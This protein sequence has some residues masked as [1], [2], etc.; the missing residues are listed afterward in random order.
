[1]A[2]IRKTI[3]LTD[4]QDQWI[5][6]QIAAGGFTNDSEYI[7]DLVRR[8]QE[9]NAQFL[10]LKQAIQEGLESGVS[11]KTVGEIWEEAEQRSKNKRG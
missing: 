3:T 5:K 1:M 10:A 9:Q 2:T 11:N 8:D 4:Q 7:R 6:T